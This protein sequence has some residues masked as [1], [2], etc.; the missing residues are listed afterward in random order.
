MPGVD[1]DV[2]IGVGFHSVKDPA[3]SIEPQLASTSTLNT[4]DTVIGDDSALLRF[5]DC[6]IDSNVA[7]DGGAALQMAS[8]PGKGAGHLI[9]HG[10]NFSQNKTDVDREGGGAVHLTSYNIRNREALTYSNIFQGCIFTG[11]TGGTAGAIAARYPQ[12]LVLDMTAVSPITSAYV[13]HNCQNLCTRN[14]SS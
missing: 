4:A 13:P 7:S 11:N 6:I 12:D 9:V 8:Y 3:T 2:F 14:A 1:E 10:C 5:H